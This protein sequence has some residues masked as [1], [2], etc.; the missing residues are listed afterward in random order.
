MRRRRQLLVT[1]L[2]LLGSSCHSFV[3]YGVRNL[4]EEPTDYADSVCVAARDCRAA[5]EAWER[6]A[7]AGPALSRGYEQ[8]FKRGYAYYLDVGE[9]GQC[10]AVPSWCYRQPCYDNPAGYLARE[11]WLAGFRAGMEAARESGLHNF[12]VMPSTGVTLRGYP[13]VPIE[14]PGPGPAASGANAPAGPRTPAPDQLPPPRP[15]P[16][17][18]GPPP[19]GVR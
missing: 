9:P 5:D 14:P 4:V 2:C 7:Q 15:L 16:P 17:P 13:Y 3:T 18:P 8:G 11:D 19:E 1:A 10:P 6:L 12:V